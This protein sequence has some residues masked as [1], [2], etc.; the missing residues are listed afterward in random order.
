MESSILEHQSTG[1]K[2]W[3]YY[4][5]L[6]K[7]KLGSQSHK[8]NTMVS[9][10]LQGAILMK[11]IATDV[12]WKEHRKHRWFD[13][14]R[15]SI[16]RMCLV[17]EPRASCPL[18]WRPPILLRESGKDPTLLVHF[19]AEKYRWVLS[20]PNKIILTGCCW[21]SWQRLHISCHARVWRPTIWWGE[22]RAFL[23]G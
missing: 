13:D 18:K 14:V 15:D 11:L 10:G 2:I 9:L 7:F 16:G 5:L 23:K 6:R 22:R 20:I 3:I 12:A 21:P 4:I 1:G 8:R 17:V 19:Q